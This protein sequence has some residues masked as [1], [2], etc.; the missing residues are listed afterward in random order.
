MKEITIGFSKSGLKLPILAYLIIFWESLYWSLKFKKIIIVEQSHCYLKFDTRR[1]FDDY[2]VY[3][4]AKGMVHYLPYQTFLEK[5]KMVKEIKIMVPNNIYWEIRKKL[6]K[7][8]GKPYGMMQN[9]GIIL[10]DIN[11][12][13]DRDVNNPWKKGYNCSEAAGEC[14]IYLKEELKTKINLNKI[15]PQGIRLLAEK[16]FEE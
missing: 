7:R 12:L 1:I 11:D 15:K 2:I 8:I 9:L 16:H 3:H 10:T 4:A 13:L 14:M 5:N 6:N